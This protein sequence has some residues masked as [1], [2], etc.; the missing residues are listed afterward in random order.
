MSPDPTPDPSAS[1]VHSTV[2][3]PRGP[4]CLALRPDAPGGVVREALVSPDR[5]VPEPRKQSQVDKLRK[6]RAVY[7]FQADVD[8]ER[9]R[10]FL[11]L[12]RPSSPKEY[13]EELLF[14]RRAVRS[15]ACALEAERRGISVAHHYG[16]SHDRASRLRPLRSA[17]LMRGLPRRDDARTV[18]KHEH[19]PGRPS[20]RRF[21]RALGEFAAE[22]HRCGM[23]HA[24]LKLGNIFVTD[25]TPRFALIDLDRTSFPRTGGLR[26]FVGELFDLRGLLSS[27]DDG[28]DRS[29]SAERRL[30]LAAWLRKRRLSRSARARRLKWLSCI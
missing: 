12:Y 17:L 29:T 21:L 5:F 9:V 26:A 14:G 1:V 7:S 19:P 8:G 28:G 4:T 18:L 15:L 24:D 10:L 13:L 3:G 16:A 23:V 27:M 20:R 6:R 11:K 2:D 30:V 22:M 25:P